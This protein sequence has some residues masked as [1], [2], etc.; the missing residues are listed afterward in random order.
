M[1]VSP[2]AP[3]DPAAPPNPSVAT[4]PF[5]QLSTPMVNPDGRV[6]FA[7]QQLFINLWLRVGG[8]AGVPTTQIVVVTQN[9]TS[10]ANATDANGVAL[11]QIQYTGQAGQTTIVLTVG[12]SP[13]VYVAPSSGAVGVES[14]QVE[15]SRD[16]GVTF[17]VV[18]LSGGMIPMR[19][20]DQVRVTYYNDPPAMEFFGD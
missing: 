1:S 16:G 17:Y 9:N 5:P 3:S 8:G 20:N 4:Q 12:P 7:W 13:F 10:S 6:S 11:G 14:G 18:G 15:F 2:P 19:T